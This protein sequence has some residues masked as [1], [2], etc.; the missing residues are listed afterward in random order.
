VADAADL[1]VATSAT[2]GA[3]STR[4]QPW[5]IKATGGARLIRLRSGET[6]PNSGSTPACWRN[7]R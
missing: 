7:D 3:V 5:L 6:R 2:V 4:P 1:D